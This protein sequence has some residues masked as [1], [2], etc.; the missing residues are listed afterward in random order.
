MNTAT[1]TATCLLRRFA[2]S[3]QHSSQL[4]ARISSFNAALA[5]N[6]LSADPHSASLSLWRPQRQRR[7]TPTASFASV[8][9]NN[10]AR[11]CSSSSSPHQENS[12]L[13]DESLDSD[14]DDEI[15][16]GILATQIKLVKGFSLTTSL[17]SLSC[18]PVLYYSLQSGA[19]KPIALMLGMGAF[20]SFFTFAT[21]L[22]VHY[23]SKKYV[24][25][26]YYNRITDTY[27]AITYSL[28]LRKKQIQFRPTDVHVPD[29]PG[30]FT[31]FKARNV[32][33]FVESGQFYSIHHYG[34]IMGYEKP[35]PSA[36][37]WENKVDARRK[38][39]GD[40]E[41]N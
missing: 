25:E 21:P 11:Q 38:E 3:Q 19:E 1:V 23:M 22:M 15:Y 28:F 12:Q 40:E 6:S 39:V 14:G 7:R 5:R 30:M 16:R 8:V 10:L 26:M 36:T 32:P 41:K 20:M 35:L 2:V 33:L 17:I 34:K 18:Q 31:T 24:T 13:P 4:V 9:V 27:T 37:R 29:I